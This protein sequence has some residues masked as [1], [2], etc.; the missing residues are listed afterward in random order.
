MLTPED[1][2]GPDPPRDDGP[3]A[4]TWDEYEAWLLAQWRAL[5][6]RRPDAREMQ[7]FLE[8]HPS[9]LP[10]AFPFWGSAGGG[11]GAYP[12]VLITQPALQGLGKRIP[13]FL[14]IARDTASVR[15]VFIEIED[16]KKRW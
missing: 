11:H 15:P 4:W 13:D 5:L 7:R 10:G 6:E 16:P 2:L 9:L 12:N 14:W 8:Q 1:V 3:P